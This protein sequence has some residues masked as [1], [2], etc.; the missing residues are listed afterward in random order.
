VIDFAEALHTSFLNADAT[1]AEY[2]Y[3]GATA[4]V[5]IV[6]RSGEDRYLQAAN[7][8]DSAAFLW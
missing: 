1:I 6:W 2:Q 8:G 7:V 5:I 3:V 4:T